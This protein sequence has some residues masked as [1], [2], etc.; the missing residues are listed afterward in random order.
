[1]KK[2]A[3]LPWFHT[4]NA[5]PGSIVTLDDDDGKHAR[6]LRLGPGDSVYCFNGTGALF[7]G[8]LVST[9]KQVTIKISDCVVSEKSPKSQISLAIAP[10]KNMAR[11]EWVIEK[12]TEIGV[13][14]ILPI[15]CHHSERSKLNVDRMERIAVSACKQSKALWI[16]KIHELSNFKCIFNHGAPQKWI[17][18]CH[19]MSKQSIRSLEGS[20]SKLLAIGPEGDFSK[21]EVELAIKAGFVGLDLGE[22]RLRTE[23]AAIMA[24]VASHIFQS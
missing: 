21:E 3:D 12:A 2:S 17:A 22:K 8:E 7:A 23:T 4:A 13:Q 15:R 18:H 5:R 11:L 6:V 14:E 1:M 20:V 10:T 16:P 9:G 24:I 19:D